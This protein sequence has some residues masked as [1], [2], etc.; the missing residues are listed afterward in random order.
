MKAETKIFGLKIFDTDI[1]AMATVYIP[2]FTVLDFE[3]VQTNFK[4]KVKVFGVTVAK[5]KAKGWV[6]TPFKVK[7]GPISGNVKGGC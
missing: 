5:H 2:Q 1:Q 6:L 3:G 4:N 7:S